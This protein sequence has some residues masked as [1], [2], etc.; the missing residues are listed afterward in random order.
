MLNGWSSRSEIAPPN[1]HERS[2]RYLFALFLLAHGLVHAL[3]L[4]PT[5]PD[6]SRKAWP[7]TLATSPILSPLAVPESALRAGGAAATVVVMAAF[8]LSA[9]GAAGI[10]GLA[11]AWTAIT[12]FA[13]IASIVLTFAFW[14]PQFPVALLIDAV[15]IVTILGNW[16]PVTLVR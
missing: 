15:L 5:P 9:L 14:N 8:V 2:M 1:R 6:K 13:S 4:V 3:W 10:P 11:P 16:W 7:F 12:L